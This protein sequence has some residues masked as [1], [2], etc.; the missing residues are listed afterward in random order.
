MPSEMTIPIISIFLTVFPPDIS[1]GY[2]RQELSKM[3]KVTF[4]EVY[5]N[6]YVRE[7]IQVL[8]RQTIRKYPML[9]PN[10][11]EIEQEILIRLNSAL[12]N[13]APDRGASPITFTRRIL[14]F[15][16]KD[17]LRLHFSKKAIKRRCAINFDDVFSDAE[18]V[19]EKPAVL[20]ELRM[21]IESVMRF[22][23][24]IRREICRKLMDGDSYTHIAF[25]LK[26]PRWELVGRHIPAIREV[27]QHENLEKY[28]EI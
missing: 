11:G 20:I 19:T 5:A 8:I 3:K 7:S 6:A 14:N 22:L 10:R 4:E 28:L 21:D 15:A 1:S 2:N 12:V 26:I 17:I 16:L 9:A 27:F 13:Y 25:E 24:P 23:T 18:A